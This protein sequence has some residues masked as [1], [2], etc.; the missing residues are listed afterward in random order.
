M[1]VSRVLSCEVYVC[2]LMTWAGV[3]MYLFHALLAIS[4]CV[5][6]PCTSLALG[7]YLHVHATLRENGC[8]I[9]VCEV[10]A[11]ALVTD[12]NSTVEHCTFP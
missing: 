7:T 2:K 10:V 1:E 3:D 12:G 8:M 4:L 11:G 9:S 5:F 6:D